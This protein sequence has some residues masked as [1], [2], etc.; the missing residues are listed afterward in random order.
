ML[1]PRGWQRAGQGR[2][3][4]GEEK[5]EVEGS[6]GCLD[7]AFQLPCLDQR[8]GTPALLRSEEVAAPG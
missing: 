8:Q 7:F 4:Q 2:A 1:L 6:G 5:D 3:G